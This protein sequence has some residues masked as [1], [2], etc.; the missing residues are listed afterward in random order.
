MTTNRLLARLARGDVLI[1]DGAAGT[2]LQQAG[3]PV[4][5]APDRW[6][7]DQPT[8]ILALH[9]AYLD[10]GA[11]VIL[12][13]TFGG[14]RPRLAHRHL[15][16]QVEAINMA[17]ARLAREATGERAIVLGD[18]GPTGQM[19]S[20][21]G[22]LRR[23]DAVAVF[24]EQAAALAQ[25]DV[26]ALIIETMS[27]LAEATAAVEGAQQATNLPV[28]VTMS[29]DHKGRTMMGV[30]PE[31]AARALWALGVTAIGANCGRTLSETLAAVTRMHEA[32][33]EAVLMAKPNAGLP[34]LDG[35]D[36]VYD[37]TPAIMADYA[38]QFAT[39]GVRIIGGCCG[40]TPDHIR[41]IAQ[42]LAV[43]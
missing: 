3:L 14:T 36:L 35:S 27:D 4:G 11:D 24:A 20:P 5:E 39:L 12:T 29:F 7:L 31:D 10:A 32:V 26:D 15:D 1:A 43:T 34:H 33:P 40:S 19:M 21:L 37:V 41:A 18:I 22:T 13:N 6:N 28:L 16:D 30:K 17:G 38:R 9:R 23:E 42:A 8:A 2:M 25:G